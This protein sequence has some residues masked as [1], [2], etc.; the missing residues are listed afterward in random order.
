MYRGVIR[1]GVA[2]V[3]AGV[4]ILSIGSMGVAF[5]VPIESP[6]FQV[7]EPEFGAG[8]ALESCS[9]EYCAQASIG[10]PVAGN[11]S[12][13]SY[14][15]EFSEVEPDSD[16]V[17][18]VIV[19]PGETDLGVLST[20]ETA[21]K[22][23]LVKVRNYLSDGYMIQIMGKAPAY[24]GHSLATFRA[25]TESDPGT[26]MFGIN[27]VANSSPQV[28]RDVEHTSPEVP[29][30]G[31]ILDGYDKANHFK[32]EEGDVLARSESESSEMIYTISMVVNISNDTPAGHYTGDFSA[33][34]IPIF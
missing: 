18:E 13:G 26:E 24:D 2:L 25:P 21:S 31:L 30:V 4:L 6:S 14:T 8:A 28:G 22:T 1:R 29:G 27:L 17:L 16:P 34:V 9:G 5:A 33:V 23:T 32:Y 11:S 19:E 12:G 3:G 7:S 10:N 20:S 15:A